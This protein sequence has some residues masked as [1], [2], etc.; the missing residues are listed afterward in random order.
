MPGVDHVVKTI[1]ITHPSGLRVLTPNTPPNHSS[2]KAHRERRPHRHPPPPLPGRR[3]RARVVAVPCASGVHALP[4]QTTGVAAA[5]GI[6]CVFAG[7]W[8]PAAVAGQWFRGYR[9]TTGRRLQRRAVAPERSPSRS[10]QQR[11]GN[12]WFRAFFIAASFFLFTFFAALALPPGHR[13]TGDPRSLTVCCRRPRSTGAMAGL[14][15]E[16]REAGVRRTPKP[17]SISGVPLLSPPDPAACAARRDVLGLI[18]QCSDAHA[19]FHRNCGRVKTQPKW[20]C[21]PAGAPGISLFVFYAC[22]ST[23]R[24]PASKSDG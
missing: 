20:R 24:A 23:G 17:L 12:Q 4:G 6:Q 18:T 11:P 10:L 3:G 2:P 9:S 15:I 7:Q 16:S 5:H 1:Y 21:A 8:Q 14:P 19:R 22:S 13:P